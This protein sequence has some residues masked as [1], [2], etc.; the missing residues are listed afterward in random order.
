MK[1][2][3]LTFDCYGTLIDWRAG[4]E[5]S[6]E[7]AFG[8]TRL[9]GRELMDAYIS[10]EKAEEASYM[11]YREILVRSAQR[12]GQVIGL[13]LEESASRK[14]AASVPSWPAFEDTV[15]FLKEAGK[16]GYIRYILSNVDVDL[17]EGTIKNNELEVDGYVTAEEVKSYKPKWRHWE[18]FMEKTG[19]GKNEMLHVAQSLYH[20]VVPTQEMGIASAWINRYRG[21]LPAG[22]QPLA[23]SDS[24]ANF[25]KVLDGLA[26]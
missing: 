20:D 13:P 25:G 8:R 26:A 1:F 15:K 14:F 24:L 2:R 5:A 6:L 23:I 7:E 12:V 16:K 3:Y 22:V 10:A 11:K 19:A 21:S 17:L 9:K 4:I 18:R